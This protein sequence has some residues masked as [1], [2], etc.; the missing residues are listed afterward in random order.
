[1]DPDRL[2]T[3]VATEYPRVVA[4][5]AVLCGEDD[6][7]EDCVQEALAR[8]CEQERRGRRIDN[9]AAWVTTV[10]SNESRSRFRR[11]GRERRAYARHGARLDPPPDPATSADEL[12]VRRAVASLP[13]RHRQA[14][15][16]RYFLGLD[17]AEVAAVLGIADGTVKALLFQGRRRLGA[18]LAATSSA[19]PVL[20]TTAGP[21]TSPA[22]LRGG[23]GGRLD[24]IGEV[25]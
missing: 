5:V 11:R 16:L 10:A 1:V 23:L 13:L 18:T 9:L 2:R 12:T 7:A 14:I 8:A 6:L 24:E 25:T 19:D 17:L 4:V 21:D 15:A 20:G 22:S 3:F